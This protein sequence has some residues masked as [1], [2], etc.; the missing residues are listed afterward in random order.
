MNKTFHSVYKGK[1]KWEVYLTLALGAD[2]CS[3][4][5]LPGGTLVSTEQEGD[6]PPGTVWP[7][8]RRERCLV[9]MVCNSFDCT[10]SL[11]VFYRMLETLQ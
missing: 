3:A 5:L 6:W 11:L 7:F 1:G 4:A 10:V 8:W 2:E 9:R